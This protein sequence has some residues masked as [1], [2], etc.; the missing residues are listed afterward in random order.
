MNETTIE[1]LKNIINRI[2]NITDERKEELLESLDILVNFDGDLR[3]NEEFKDLFRSL[4]EFVL[5][6]DNYSKYDK[7]LTDYDLSLEATVDEIEAKREEVVGKLE[8]RAKRCKYVD[9]YKEYRIKIIKL[10]KDFDEMVAHVGN[11]VLNGDLKEEEVKK[12][13]KDSINELNIFA[14]A[15]NQFKIDKSPAKEEVIEYNYTGMSDEEIEEAKKMLDEVPLVESNNDEHD[16]LEPIEYFANTN[17]RKPRLQGP[18]ESN[19]D[20]QAFLTDYYARYDFTNAKATPIEETNEF[21]EGKVEY[22]KEKIK[23]YFDRVRSAVT[24]L[25]WLY[26]HSLNEVDSLSN[27]IDYYEE[28][29]QANYKVEAE[30]ELEVHESFLSFF[31][32]KLKRINE[33]TGKLFNEKPVKGDIVVSVELERNG[34]EV[35]TSITPLLSII[36]EELRK[37]YANY[38]EDKDK[39]KS[40]DDEYKF[41]L[42]DVTKDDLNDLL[43]GFID[44]VTENLEDRDYYEIMASNVEVVL[45]GEEYVMPIKDFGTNVYKLFKDI[46]KKNNAQVN[47]PVQDAVQTTTDEKVLTKTLDKYA[48][49][50][51][52][53]LEDRLREIESE[54]AYRTHQ[55]NGLETHEDDTLLEEYR[56]IKDRL[57]N[58][59]EE[60]NQDREVTTDLSRDEI[61]SRMN[62]LESEMSFR[63]HQENGLET[64]EDDKLIEEYTDLSNRLKVIDSRPATVIDVEEPEVE[65][66]KTPDEIVEETISDITEEANKI[67][68]EEKSAKEVDE[69]LVETKT[70]D[71]I[72]PPKLP[73]GIEQKDEIN[74]DQYNPYKKSIDEELTRKATQAD[75]APE[76]D[77]IYGEDLTNEPKSDVVKETSGREDVDLIYGESLESD[78]KETEPYEKPE[79]IDMIYGNSLE[80]DNKEAESYEKPEGIDMIYGEDVSDKVTPV[81]EEVVE[82]E[83]EEQEEAQSY[84][85]V[86]SRK[87]ANI[88]WTLGTVGLFGAASLLLNNVRN[89][90]KSAILSG[91]VGAGFVLSYNFDNIRRAATKHKLKRL[92]SDYNIKLFFGDEKIEARTQDGL[93]LDD[94]AKGWFQEALDEKFNA[95]RH[96]IPQV[97]VDNLENAFIY[98]KKKDVENFYM[99]TEKEN[100][101]YELVKDITKF[102]SVGSHEW[103]DDS[104]YVEEPEE[105]EDEEEMTKE[106]LQSVIAGLQK[107]IDDVDTNYTYESFK[108]KLIE[109]NPGIA[110]DIIEDNNED[111][112]GFYIH[113]ESPESIILPEGF[114]NINGYITNRN[115]TSGME[116][117]IPAMK[118]DPEDVIQQIISEFGEQLMCP[119]DD[120]LVLMQ[121]NPQYKEE[122]FEAAW[123]RYTSQR[124]K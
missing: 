119:Y 62:E 1:S 97:T 25:R 82:E 89:D 49:Y 95:K 118:K 93:Q 45:D 7:L 40:V 60:N 67:L 57:R 38:T 24:D 39:S 90:A 83:L 32:S 54:M 58:L 6:Q 123:D 11:R 107:Q 30:K 73:I 36:D 76:L 69:S 102:E 50:N 77:M 16:Y 71:L 41:D 68:D 110:K 46:I 22:T 84:K 52:S 91:I 9:Q 121:A 116:I 14:K 34:N 106:D 26:N 43:H 47:A 53:D 42:Y 78:N 124:V 79:G 28:N 37:K 64:H 3:H 75:E 105:Q 120:L 18:Y 65:V 66:Q 13:R 21:Y 99:N 108:Q 17:V 56:D 85:V 117:T 55:E 87:P 72:L 8:A 33:I 96:D 115:T 113:T 101:E 48:S 109:L 63:T 35:S 70:D 20:Y 5:K 111:V 114:E 86:S 12:V 92:A 104:S 122:D 4:Q 98:N 80:N 88:G 100:A 31:E 29:N 51:K 23:D 19:E 94:Q 103:L 74:L 59:D 81:Q 15:L 44:S 27:D 2:D 10:N 112:R 61:V